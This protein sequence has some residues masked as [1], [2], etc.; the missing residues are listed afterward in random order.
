MSSQAED[1]IGYASDSDEAGVVSPF[2]YAYTKGNELEATQVSQTQ[3]ASSA[4]CDAVSGAAPLMSDTELIKSM[5]FWSKTIIDWLLECNVLTKHIRPLRVVSACVGLGSE[6]MTLKA[7]DVPVQD[8]HMMDTKKASFKFCSNQYGSKVKCFWPSMGE[9][10]QT[11]LVTNPCDV[12]AI[13]ICSGCPDVFLQG[14][15]DDRAPTFDNLACLDCGMATVGTPKP[16][17]IHTVS[18]LFSDWFARLALD[19]LRI[20]GVSILAPVFAVSPVGSVVQPSQSFVAQVLRPGGPSKI[21]VDVGFDCRGRKNTK[22][23]FKSL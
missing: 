10:C 2:H 7:L 18:P 3:T 11:S 23:H 21:F 6:G 20:S 9:A 16:Q 1:Q 14:A 5:F 12:F 13:L 8:F 19:K 22:P 4:S 15:S 17:P